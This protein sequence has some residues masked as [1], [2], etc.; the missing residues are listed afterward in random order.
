MKLGYNTNG[1][2]HHE[3]V[4]A[5]EMLAEIGYRSVAI[6]I[7]H[8]WLAPLHDQRDS[9]LRE[10]RDC[11]ASHKMDCV[12]ESG[13]RFL[14]DP[15]RKHYPTLLDPDQ[16]I[17]AKRVEF[18]KYCIDTAVELKADCVSIWSGQKPEGIEDQ[19][20][21]DTLA[22][23]L[24]GVLQHAEQQNMEIGFEPE[25]DMF[26]DT[27]KSY[28]RLL[29]WIDSPRLGLTLDIGHLFCMG[30][31]PIVD[32]IQRWQDRILNVHIE[33][34]RAGIHEHLMFGEGQIYFPPIL[35]S[36]MEIGYT[37]GLHVELSRHSHDAFNIARQSFDFLANTISELPSLPES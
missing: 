19:Q 32:F 7:D 28:E 1:L 12:V 24:A 13:A 17:A 8:A 25:P 34:M 9:Q 23:N 14:L 21:L 20:A 30:E 18:L 26:I 16:A 29:E 10:I 36:L 3:P 6:T 2:A 31:L 11:L 22:E 35:Q 33:D 37:G 5:L 4:Q 15:Y 27:M